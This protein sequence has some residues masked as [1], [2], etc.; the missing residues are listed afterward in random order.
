MKLV[1]QVWAK[2]T[3]HRIGQGPWSMVD[4]CDTPDAAKGRADRIV[5]NEDDVSE[6]KI[7][8]AQELA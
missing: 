6:V 3:R 4:M 1:Y 8:V 7:I 5:L 2:Y